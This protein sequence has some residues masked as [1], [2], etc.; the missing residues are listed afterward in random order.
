MPKKNYVPPT[1]EIKR[2]S[3]G[4]VLAGSPE[5]FSGYIDPDPGD[6]GDPIINDGEIDW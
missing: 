1:L 3:C 2:F 6:W 5:N 4:D